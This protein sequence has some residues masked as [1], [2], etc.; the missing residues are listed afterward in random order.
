MSEVKLHPG[1]VAML[2]PGTIPHEDILKYAGIELPQR[3]IDNR[4]PAPP[5]S[6]QLNF[7]INGVSED[8]ASD[9]RCG[10]RVQS[11]SQGAGGL[12]GG[13][14]GCLRQVAGLWH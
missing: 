11:G 7:V 8:H 6:L 3:I 1:R 13:V 9:G 10:V 12:G 2:G 5:I 4:Y 14:E